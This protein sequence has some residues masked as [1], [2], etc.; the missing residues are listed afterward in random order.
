MISEITGWPALLAEMEWKSLG[1]RLAYV[2]L[3]LG[4]VLLLLFLKTR[5]GYRIG[6][7]YFMVTLLGIPFR[8]VHLGNIRNIHSVRIRWAERWRNQI[9]ATADRNLV[10]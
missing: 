2:G 3:W 4:A 6:K 1:P 9:F 8:L 7:K 5:I 10:I